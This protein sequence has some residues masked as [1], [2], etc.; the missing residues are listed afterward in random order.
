MKILINNTVLLFLF[1]LCVISTFGQDSYSN[2]NTYTVDYLIDSL[3]IS[4][5]IDTKVKISKRIA[6]ELKDNDWERCS[7]YI[8]LT[9]KYAL[10][11]GVDKLIIASYKEIADIYY[12]KDLLDISLEYYLK[13]YNLC[14]NNTP[15]SLKQDLQNDLAVIHAKLENKK[16]ALFFFTKILE[17]CKLKKDT[18]NLIKVYNNLGLLLLQDNLDS[19]IYYFQTSLIMLNGVENNNTSVYLNTNLGRA[20]LMKNDYQKSIH[21]FAKALQETHNNIAPK[22]KAWVFQSVA[23]YYLRTALIDSSIFY[24]KESLKLLES[25]Q[26]TFSYKD[27][28]KVLYKAYLADSNYKL[29]SQYF[30]IYDV[31]RDS[32][33]IAQKAVN[34][35]K[36]KLEQEYYVKDKK[37][38]LEESKRNTKYLILGFS[39][40]LIL[41]LIF[42][43][44]IKY[45]NKLR[46]SKLENELVKA[47]KEELDIRLELKN[48]VLIAKAMKEINRTEFI[49]DILTDL[50]EIKIKAVKKETQ[51]A[52]SFIQKR[53]EKDSDS[54]IWEEFELSFEQVHERFYN[55]LDEKHPE[56]TSKDKRLCALLVLNL[57]SKEIAQITGQDYKSVENSRTRLRKKLELTNTKTDL[58]SYLNDLKQ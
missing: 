56:L 52:I 43:L 12:S 24:A 21:F 9:E 54:N 48:K 31:T 39:L 46:Q 22:T 16:Q 41:L 25:E 10:E 57:T 2:N 42:I 36:I 5:S 29:A 37:R 58:I 30:E 11:S 17:T 6:W 34:A 53:L 27:A 13:A 35:E 18:I 15:K 1:T 51:Q 28:L 26:Y 7:K 4:S 49:Q 8:Y 23:D 55:N 14:S 33:N 50:K 44:L 40:V 19:A 20:Y 38:N 45:K 32:L 3:A 47:K